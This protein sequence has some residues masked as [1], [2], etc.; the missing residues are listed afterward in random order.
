VAGFGESG[1]LHGST[2]SGVGH[3]K[4]V[5]KNKEDTT[6]WDVKLKMAS[7]VET[8]INTPVIIGKTAATRFGRFSKTAH[9]VIA[10]IVAKT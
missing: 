2:S 7:N 6:I 3:F 10:F 9:L 4:R 5:M 8:L 1:R